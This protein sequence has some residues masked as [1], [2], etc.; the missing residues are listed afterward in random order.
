VANDDAG[1][2]SVVN[3]DAAG[4]TG[5]VDV[6]GDTP[7]VA[8]N[9]QAA[10]DGNSV[11]VTAPVATNDGSSGHAHGGHE[12]DRH[13]YG[14]SNA[15][16]VDVIDPRSGDLVDRISLGEGIHP[17]HVVLDDDADHPFVIAMATDKVLILDASERRHL[18]TIDLGPHRGPHG[19]RYVAGRLAVANM[20]AGSVSIVEVAGGDV[21]EVDVGGAP[22]KTGGRA[23]A[24]M[25]TQ[26]STTRERSFDTTGKRIPSI[27]PHSLRWRRG[28]SSSTSGRPMV[29]ST[30]PI[31]AFARIDQLRIDSLCWT[32]NRSKSSDRS[33]F[34]PGPTESLSTTMDRE[35]SRRT[36][37]KNTL[38]VVTL[39]ALAEW[40]Q[41][42]CLRDIDSP[43]ELQAD[44][45]RDIK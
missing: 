1:T 44:L 23:T 18:D 40:G 42:A 22:V 27:G 43:E 33:P 38:S 6:A 16:Q 28:R 26:R 37:S 36:P 9:V 34:G 2:V 5:T 32:P 45:N 20:T 35:R 8:H 41:P 29:A 13:D 25:P 17:T 4:V 30:S 24:A 21:R 12:H 15:D 11:W 31:R 3:P 14:A 10:P 7:R 39:A 19:L